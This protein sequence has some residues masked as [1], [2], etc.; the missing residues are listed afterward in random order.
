MISQQIY[1]RN[2]EFQVSTQLTV[3]SDHFVKLLTTE[4]ERIESYRLRYEVFYLELGWAK[5]A[6][7][8]LEIDNY[9]R[10]AIPLGSYNRYHHLEA[11]LRIVRSEDHFMLERDFPYLL[12]QCHTFRKGM[13]TIEISKLCL[14]PETRKEKISGNFGTYPVSQ[15]LFKGVYIWCLMNN[16]RY[17]YM[18]VAEKVFRLLFARGFPCKLA[19][20]PH[21]M[22]DGIV[23]V[24]AVLDWREFECLCK[25]KHSKMFAWFSQNQR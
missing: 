23:T 6:S 18:V 14:K 16:I 24:A 15:L 11:Y 9:D 2:T 13:D 7:N 22:P 5:S 19:G 12:S 3:E 8:T 10:W 1:C 17:I 20:E 4:S 25:I 21:Y